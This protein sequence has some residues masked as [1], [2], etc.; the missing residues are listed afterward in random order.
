MR[1]LMRKINSGNVYMSSAS[2][3]QINV[4]P[5]KQEFFPIKSENPVIQ[6]NISQNVNCKSVTQLEKEK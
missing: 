3:K 5:V 1:F 6:I 4:K 2:Q